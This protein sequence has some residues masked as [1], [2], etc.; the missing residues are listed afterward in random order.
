MCI[1]DRADPYKQEIEQAIHQLTGD[2]QQH[3]ELVE[4]VRDLPEHLHSIIMTNPETKAVY[5]D[6]D[7]SV[8]LMVDNQLNTTDAVQSVLHE[9]VGHKGIRAVLGD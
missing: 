2:I 8:Y 7:G 1:R 9:V 4:S 3:V 5:D 6:S